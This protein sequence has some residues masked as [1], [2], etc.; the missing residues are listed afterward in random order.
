MRGVRIH[1]S[2]IALE[3]A[4]ECLRAAAHIPD[5]NQ[6][7][8]LARIGQRLIDALNEDARICAVTPTGPVANDS[9]CREAEK[10]R[11]RDRPA[12]A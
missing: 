6:S 8:R 4:Q 10:A 9:E 5:R 1:V 7:R 2:D 12:S 11:G 3:C